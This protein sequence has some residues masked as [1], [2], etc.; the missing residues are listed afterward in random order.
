MKVKVRAY[1]SVGLSSCS[2]EDVFDLDC[3][4][5]EWDNLTEEERETI[6]QDVLDDHLANSMDCG[7]WV[8]V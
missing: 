3:S 4:K 5:E 8:E 6:L 2:V 7:A 1:V